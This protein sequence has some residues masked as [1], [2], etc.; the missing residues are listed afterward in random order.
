MPE[1]DGAAT[2]LVLVSTAMVLL[3]TPALALFYGGM[4]RSFSVLN[5]MMM[6]FIAIPLVAVAWLVAG[7][8]L[9]FSDDA[10]FGL[11]GG[12]V[13]TANVS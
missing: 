6:S 7:Y 4:V 9:A 8:S 3:M 2:A 5:M 1:L 12:V 13:I 10:G 11:I